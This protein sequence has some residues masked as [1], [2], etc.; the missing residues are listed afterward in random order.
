MPMNLLDGGDIARLNNHAF[1]KVINT[2]LTVEA[3]ENHVPLLD[4]ELNTRD[5]DPDAGIDARIRWP[6]SPPHD[7]LP[8]GTTA[9]QY[10]S[11]KLTSADLTKEL[12][13]KGV[14]Q[15]LRGGGSYRL[16]VAHDY[17]SATRDKRK[18][19]LAQLCKKK[20]L[21]ASRCQILYGDQVARWVSRFLSVV[22]LP[23]LGK[24]FPAFATVERWRQNPIFQNTYHA[25]PSREE[26][27]K[28]IRRFVSTS[29]DENILRVEGPA[30]VGKTRLLLEALAVPEIADNIVYAPDNRDVR[31]R[32]E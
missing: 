1:R 16:L 14:R 23:E 10:K 32:L 22:L 30:G 25:D 6:S 19:E 4:V 11:G 29:A 13:E 24:V 15:T 27:I 8:A 18:K 28:I 31:H 5:T 26:L 21:P 12:G 7:F 17:P 2:L 9:L 3:N 20:H